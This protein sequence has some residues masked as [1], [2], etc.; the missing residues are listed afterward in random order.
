MYS[1]KSK[2]KQ[3]L[4]RGAQV[5]VVVVVII[6]IVGGGLG[7]YYLTKGGG[8][9]SSTPTG[10][11]TTTSTTS[12]TTT[13][14][15]TQT[16]PTPVACTAPSGAS[17]SAFGISVQS[18][19]NPPPCFNLPPSGMTI[20]S[21]LT[22]YYTNAFQYLDPGVSYYEQDY[23]IISTVY[24]TLLAY[25]GTSPTQTVPWLVQNY[26]V[27]ASGKTANFTLR[28]GVT[29]QDGEALNSTAVYF[30]LTRLLV[31]DGSSPTSHGSQASWIVQQMV[32][33][34]LSTTLSGAKQT[35]GKAYA[36]AWIAKNFVQITGTYT[37]TLN[38]A[39]PNAALQ[40]LLA[41]DWASIVAPDWV[42]SHD[43]A[44]WTSGYTLPNP[45]LSG[46][47]AGMINQYLEDLSATCNAGATLTGCGETSLDANTEALA[48]G[49]SYAPL[50]GSGPY[51]ITSFDS[52]SQAMTLQANT[53]YWGGGYQ[54]AGAQ[55]K[56][57]AHIATISLVYNPNQQT[58]ETQLLSA[59]NAGQ[60][61]QM[62]LSAANLYDLASKATWNGG[63]GT[64]V[65]NSQWTGK[66]FFVPPFS[67]LASYFDTFT[68]NVTSNG[69]PQ[70]F[71]PFADHR[72]RLAFADA[73]NLTEI[74]ADYNN[75]LGSVAN[76]VFPPGLP[77]AGSYNASAP[78]PYSF[79]P[80]AAAQLLLS[81][82]E[83]PLTSFVYTNGT[84]AYKPGVINNTFGCP[85]LTGLTCA[86][87]SQTPQ[88]ITLTVGAG[89]AVD[90]AQ[91]T[92]IANTINNISSTYSMKLSVV[93]TIEP[94]GVL[95]SQ[96]FTG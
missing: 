79:N 41:G 49:S 94:L 86:S 11:T 78:L 45:T 87:G 56:T 29:F 31:E 18:T 17:T 60:A 8:T 77:P 37:F 7:A 5:A 22:Y 93:I 58:R 43:M 53:G 38:M 65:P 16:G 42:M 26:T 57:N 71:Q 66:I 63:A 67:S 55:Y 95:Y 46:S 82:M 50:A 20:P 19:T 75:G 69:V 2:V 9:T 6:I 84:T 24:E 36:D 14:T 72:I 90:L 61:A 47:G 13:S 1:T 92:Q 30:T 54:S 70:K 64:L 51:K 81:A 35:Y 85:T 12:T 34:S 15:S 33:T 48:S 3:A 4:T 44:M 68:T 62:D 28:Q 59:A 21:T 25:N 39:I 83:H 23:S 73:V 80:D 76:S 91:F 27:S 32:N 96:L 10:T 40:Y 88:T 52:A 74:N 89:D